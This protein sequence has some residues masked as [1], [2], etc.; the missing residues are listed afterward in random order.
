VRALTITS[1]TRPSAKSRADQPLARLLLDSIDDSVRGTVSSAAYAGVEADALE[2]AVFIHKIAPAV[3]VHLRDSGDAPSSLIEPMMQR[4]QLQVARQLQ[5]LSDLAGLSNVLTD[6]GV[7]WAAMKGPVLAERLW[8]RPDLRTYIDLDILVDRRRFGD[9]LDTLI[10]HGSTMVD[11]NWS[12]IEQQVRAEVS[13]TLPNGTSLDLHWHVVNQRRLRS[14][15]TFPIADMLA[16]AV[17]AK[18]GGTT[19]PTLDPADT[20]L[21][22]A[23]H[24]AHSGGHRL[25]W[26]KDVERATADPDLDWAETLRRARAYHVR[27]PL[28]IVLARTA[29]S[30]GFE[31]PPPAA[32]FAAAKHSPWGVFAATTDRWSPVPVLP[33][34]KF[35]GQLAFKTARRSTASSTLAAID[36]VKRRREP[37]FDPTMNELYNEVGGDAARAAYLAVVQ[38]GLEP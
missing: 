4:Y 36:A 10:A 17:D 32:A 25:M 24:T 23:Y 21:H 2:S 30:I 15:F 6:A 18:I 26:L 14:Q 38:G 27:L 34:D 19:V 7:A 35:S 16:R 8:S 11:Q 37:A 20:L 33:G 3:Y 5:V 28:A 13:L 12:L 1:S 22:L 31:V 9:V 29:K